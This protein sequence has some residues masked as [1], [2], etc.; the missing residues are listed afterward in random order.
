MRALGILSVSSLTAALAAGC[1]ALPPGSV[2]TPSRWALQDGWLTAPAVCRPLPGPA[3]NLRFAELGSLLTPDSPRPDLV[4]QFPDGGWEATY[5]R[6]LGAL[7][8]E[9]RPFPELGQDAWK[10]TIR[11]TNTTAATQDIV[12]LDLFVAPFSI[13][14]AR[15]WRPP[16]FRLR[17]VGGGQALCLAY[18]GAIEPA[19][20]SDSADTMEAHIGV[21]W[22]LGPG[23][24]AEV[25]HQGLW[26]GQ[27]GSEEF[28]HEARRWYA[29]HGLREPVRYP[30]WLLEGIL[31]EISAAGHIDSRFSDVGG[32]SAL[33]HQVPYLADLGVTA[34]WLNA[35][36]QH[37]TPPDPMR[38]GWNHYDPRDLA[39]V[40]PILGGDEGF[41]ELLS[42]FRRNGIRVLSEIV[43]HGG[44][45]RQ[46]EALPE[47]WTRER[48]GGLRRNWGG[49]G[50]D[51]ASPEWQAVLRESMAMVSAL[52]RIDGARI[53]VAD[54]Q[55][56]NWGSPRTPRASFST[57]GGGVEMLGAV[58]DGLRAGGCALPVLIPE[59][60]EHPAYFALPGA[61][62]LGY[63]WGLTMLLANAS[64]RTLRAA[65]EMNRRLCAELEEER[66]SL[67]PGALLLRTLNN[68]DTVCDKGRVQQ[69]F[70]AGL[71]RALYGV[72]LVLPGVP[73]L[74]QEEEVGSYEALRRLH[75]ARRAL[76]WLAHGEARYL[77][78]E[79]FDERVFTV[80]RTSGKQQAL[81]LVN[82]SGQTV[83]GSA[84]LPLAE[85]R[86][87]TDAVSGA[88]TK[89]DAAGRFS[90]TLPPYATA[91][92]SVGTTPRVRV[93]AERFPGEGAQ[94]S[95]D[96]ADGFAL[97]SDTGGF[98]ARHGGVTL[99]VCLDGP[100]WQTRSTAE[101]QFEWTSP[102]GTLTVTRRAN[103]VDVHCE[104][105]NPAA[106]P[107]VVRVEGADRWAVS[108]RT[109]LLADRFIRRQ[110]PFPEATGYRWERTHGWGHMVWGGLYQG[111]AP[112]GRLWQSLLEPLHPAN[113]A[114]GFCDRHGRG[115]L[116]TGI[117]TDAANIVLTDCTD[118]GTVPPLRLETRFLALDSDL[119]PDVQRFG[120][121]P[122]WQG[123]G[124]P[125]PDPRPLS[126]TFTLEPGSGDLRDCLAGAEPL[127][128]ATAGPTET[129]EGERF[130][131][132][133]GRVFVVSPGR[134]TW[135]D[136]PAVDATCQLELELRLS[137]RSGEDTDLGNAYRVR[138]NGVELPLTWGRRSVW[139]TGNAYF[140]LARTPP[141]DLRGTT[142]T[143]TIE[144]LHTW[145]ALR[146]RFTLVTP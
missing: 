34:V 48:D 66:G 87:L 69:R 83:T 89:T 6:D 107:L 127:P 114:I 115:L 136:L 100:P 23:Q 93:P 101:G 106:A 112:A 46:A 108:G 41:R 40:D 105:R 80:W 44:H 71:Q 29:A 22:R 110:F 67:P 128:R 7:V 117:Q 51:T 19:N 59:S 145:C 130:S 28:R 47:W 53:D 20:L 98:R 78:P 125:P 121:R 113:P 144:T 119:H 84:M 63:G 95:T 132:M 126:V 49:Y 24:T 42:T 36:Q 72:C 139:S 56:P 13:P 135:S 104:L 60:G 102:Q 88:S 39:S 76:P 25:G 73:M 30:P 9:Y 61:A 94:A 111:V 31:C 35:V 85:R 129:R 90:W 64:D 124:L 118:E 5:R 55:G 1:A 143:L 68:H 43:P 123:Q 38:G 8:D 62:V 81:C 50:M 99:S 86:R 92:L 21:C 116:L 16:T 17:E 65:A 26:L 122:P 27:A 37:K 141:V 52:G 103:S 3:L 146:P 82:L 97:D 32:F 140:A 70:G 11:Y 74:Y 14:A 138:L 77:A 2:P 58:R 79:T 120:P 33:A 57:L 109:G 75:A 142:H 131:E 15:T 18:W 134:I 54:G 96:H 10:R 137:E 12:G 45:S 133:G 91:L 4:S